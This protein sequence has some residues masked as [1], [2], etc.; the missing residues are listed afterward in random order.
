[1][2]ADNRPIHVYSIFN[3]EGNALYVGITRNIRRRFQEHARLAAW[4]SEA[5]RYQDIQMTNM[6]DARTVEKALIRAYQ[7]N[8]NI[9]HTLIEPDRLGRDLA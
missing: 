2:N 5:H 7:P 3:D 1:M 8:H 9:R 6:T 4:W